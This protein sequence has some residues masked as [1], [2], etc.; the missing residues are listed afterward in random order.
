MARALQAGQDASR[1]P[2]LRGRYY[3]YNDGRGWVVSKY[4]RKR[5][6]AQSADQ[7]ATID[8]FKQLAVY[9]KLTEAGIQNLLRAAV[10]N[11]PY[12]M[13]DLLYILLSGQGPTIITVDGERYGSVPRR[14]Q[15]SEILDNLSDTQGALL[16]RG[17]DYWVAVP[18]GAAGQYLR[19]N[20]LNNLPSWQDVSVPYVPLTCR[21]Y[22]TTTQALPAGST[23]AIQ[24][25]SSAIA[26]FAG[27]VIGSPTLMTVPA[28]ATKARLTFNVQLS[29]AADNTGLFA[30]VF[31]AGAAIAAGFGARAGGNFT[32][33]GIGSVA[34][35][36]ATPWLAVS[37]GD[38][39]DFRV[40]TA[41]GDTSGAEASTWF[42]MEVA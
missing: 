26:D 12:Y 37:P 41:A 17:Q 31:K 34:L 10:V 6:R 19:Y 5:K 29:I 39:F 25:Q 40:Q 32:N 35:Y 38:T 28:G 15:A 36:A 2:S 33:A 18:P 22:R 20:G 7:Q 16:Y 9:A 11:R 4:P 24:F 3:V 21:A 23:T 13:R 27:W 1:G 14:I 30:L 42:Q 8:W